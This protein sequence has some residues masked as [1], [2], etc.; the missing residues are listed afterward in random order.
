MSYVFSSSLLDDQGYE[1]IY[2]WRTGIA[3][4]PGQPPKKP[5]SASGKVSVEDWANPTL[6][7]Y[8]NKVK[9][10]YKELLY[11]TY[12]S[13]G[14]GTPH[15]KKYYKWEDS[16]EKYKIIFPVIQ[17]YPEELCLKIRLSS[18]SSKEMARH[19][20]IW[21]CYLK[22]LKVQS[23][24]GK[25]KVNVDRPQ[26]NCTHKK[27]VNSP[28][29]TTTWFPDGS[30]FNSS[31]TWEWEAG[32][33]GVRHIGLVAHAAQGVT[34]ANDEVYLTV[35]DVQIY[36]DINIDFFV[37]Q[38]WPS[39]DNPSLASGAVEFMREGFPV[40]PT[41]VKNLKPIRIVDIA[42][43]EWLRFNFGIKPLA[44]GIASLFN[45][46]SVIDG[47]TELM[48]KAAISGKLLKFGTH[49]TYKTGD[50]HNFGWMPEAEFEL[51]GSSQGSVLTF[52][53]DCS[54]TEYVTGHSNWS[55]KYERSSELSGFIS[56]AGKPRYITPANK[57]ALFAA[58]MSNTI[59]AVAWELVPFSWAFDYFNKGVGDL[60]DYH[61]TIEI[62]ME[63]V[64]ITHS[65]RMENVYHVA[66]DRNCDRLT[67]FGYC[68]SIYNPIRGPGDLMTHRNNLYTTETYYKRQVRTYSERPGFIE[69]PRGNLSEPSH[70]SQF[71]NLG[72]CLHLI[73]SK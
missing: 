55:H 36:N 60:I 49:P 29:D 10:W 20:K 1:S 38:N 34:F 70:W 26:H 44:L 2:S 52:K 71:L 33:A 42:A 56:V 9:V 50:L 51:I 7:P 4:G 68:G 59:G 3:A 31:P 39:L 23:G 18:R 64:E 66:L 57:L 41:T 19:P 13:S 24:C 65:L 47:V 22:A 27:L 73:L 21:N 53:D 45:S 15:Y 46:V 30:S 61:N 8:I 14:K 67:T 5:G 54:G 37:A 17:L 16:L 12:D 25:P 72:A 43:S 6:I 11:W 69:D 48:N 28:A 62:S 63:Y 35:D 58:Y 40:E 32:L